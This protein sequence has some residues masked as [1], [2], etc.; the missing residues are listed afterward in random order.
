MRVY[1][2]PTEINQMNQINWMRF[3]F[4]LR[5]QVFLVRSDFDLRVLSKALGIGAASFW[6]EAEKDIAKSPTAELEAETERPKKE[7]YMTTGCWGDVV[8]SQKKQFRED[9]CSFVDDI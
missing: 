4:I 2:C 7:D 1:K 5:L 8:V 6:S 9:S 3:A